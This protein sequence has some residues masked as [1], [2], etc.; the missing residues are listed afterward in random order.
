MKRNKYERGHLKC[1]ELSSLGNFTY[2]ALLS[3]YQTASIFQITYRQ[4]PGDLICG[5]VET[6]GRSGR[7]GAAKLGIG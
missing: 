7:M 2:W 5:E 1:K 6:R 4:V 3:D